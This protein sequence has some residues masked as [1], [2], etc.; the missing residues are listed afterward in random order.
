M[1]ASGR[2]LE[3][4]DA[5]TRAEQM[6]E[7]LVAWDAIL[8]TAFRIAPY[9]PDD[10]LTAKGFDIYEKMM[11]DAMVRA[12][13]NTKRFALLAKPWQVLPAVESPGAPPT[14]EALAARDFAE[15]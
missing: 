7:E 10:L 3:E 11:G 13:I 14:A 1:T 15:A 2:R 6:R 5:P 4:R 9:N 12:A 8:K